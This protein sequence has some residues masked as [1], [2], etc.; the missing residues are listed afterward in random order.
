MP[1]TKLTTAYDEAA[2]YAREH[3]AQQLRKG[4]NIPYIAHLLGVSSLALEMEVSE[5]EAIAALLHDVVEDG[6]GQAAADEIR[7]LF[8]D[9]VV[10]IVLACSDTDVEPKPPWR[11]RKEAYLDGIATKSPGA[12]RVSL[13]DKLHNA[14]AILLDFVTHGDAVWERFSADAEQQAWYYDSLANAFLAREADLGEKAAPLA[15]E[16]RRVVDQTIARA[17]SS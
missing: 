6:G 14:R 7:E 8:G 17:A 12:L 11:A 5:N 2:T 15:H 10:E 4:T 1:P 3:H 9:E 13:A 16:L